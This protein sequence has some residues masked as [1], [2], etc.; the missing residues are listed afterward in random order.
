MK[1]EGLIVAAIGLLLW[2]LILSPMFGISMHDLT[3]TCLGKSWECGGQEYAKP[4]HRGEYGGH[5]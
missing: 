4:L 2:I 1:Y 3:G 5:D